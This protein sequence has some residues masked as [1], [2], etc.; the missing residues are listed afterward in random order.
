[1]KTSLE[2]S[3]FVAYNIVM[4]KEWIILIPRRHAARDKIRANGAGMMGLVWVQDVEERISW[5]RLGMTKVLAY[6]GF[7]K[8]ECDSIKIPFTQR[9]VEL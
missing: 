2:V 7:P 6:M 1:M 5:T 3:S 8:E 4:V 9:L